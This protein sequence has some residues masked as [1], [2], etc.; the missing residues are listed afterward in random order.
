[1]MTSLLMQK[2]P[3]K[4]RRNKSS[5]P[6]CLGPASRFSMEGTPIIA[7]KSAEFVYY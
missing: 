1:M 5:F 7:A 6:S 4:A 2:I 3:L